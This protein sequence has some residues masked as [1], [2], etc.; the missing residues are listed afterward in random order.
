MTKNI[1]VTDENGGLIGYTYPKRVKGLVKNGRAEIV[2]DCEIRLTD[3]CPT[4][5]EISE[6]KI[7]DNNKIYFN[8]REWFPVPNCPDQQ[9]QRTFITGFDG[10]FVE[11]YM[12]GD[13]QWHWSEISTNPLQL[14]KNTRYT[15][16]FWLN[17]G[18]N[19][20][21]NEVCEFRIL[22][23]DNSMESV[24]RDSEFVFKLNRN[25]IKPLKRYKG[26]ELYEIPFTTQ[27]NLYTRLKFVSM[28]AYMTVMPALDKEAYADLKDEIDKFDGI[29]PQ[30]HNIIFADGWPSGRQSWF[31][32]ESLKDQY[33]RKN[34]SRAQFDYDDICARVEDEICAV[35]KD[36][37]AD[38]VDEYIREEIRGIIVKEFR[39][40]LRE[41]LDAES[42][43]DKNDERNDF[44]IND[45]DI[46]FSGAVISA[47]TLHQLMKRIG[48]GT[49]V[50]LSGAV[51]DDDIGDIGDM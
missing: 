13:W 27:D 41:R 32:T 46:D 34:N 19:D 26:W 40:R 30:K 47:K 49:N 50:N 20:C 7:M 33:G 12:L 43:E 16:T 31:S 45:A 35:I 3:R 42:L 4:G 5:S 8:A 51:I 22:F 44:T 6:D 25:F 23:N 10:D 17:G 48:N 1:R 14:D 2:G 28:R 37:F 24:D 9:A 29:R 36:E 11:V 21:G 39:E 38:E 15:F 18:E